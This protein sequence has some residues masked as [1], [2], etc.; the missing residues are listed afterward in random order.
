MN[1]TRREFLADVGRGML[2][3]S[4]GSA[5]ATDLGL[6]PAYADEGAKTLSF[7]PLEPLV[8]LMQET[9]ANKLLPMLVEKIQAGTDLK[10][11][12]AAGA[13]ANARTFGGQDYIGFHT[14]MALVPAFEM[15]RRLPEA[16]RPLPVF[17]VLYRNAA[18]LQESGA[19]TRD[20][21]KAVAPL[22][23]PA[24]QLTGEALR[25]AVRGRD[26]DGAERM[27]TVALRYFAFRGDRSSAVLDRLT[28]TSASRIRE[29]SAIAMAAGFEELIL[30]PMTDDEAEIDR[31][32]DAVAQA[33]GTGGR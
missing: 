28:V 3:A 26:A 9:P 10:T 23:L 29:V 30:I 33:G 18:R 8:A 24:G 25:A 2:V 5:V 6:A 11:L 7:G 12:V 15:S 31:I 17:K 21:L 13:L 27:R 1:R 19:R 32:E 16:S 20:A 4:V 22:E 14:I